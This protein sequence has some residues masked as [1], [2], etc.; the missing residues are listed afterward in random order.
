MMMPEMMMSPYV[1][2]LNVTDE[3]WN[4]LH[5]MTSQNFSGS[6]PEACD[7][8]DT[9]QH[10]RWHGRDQGLD[11]DRSAGGVERGKGQGGSKCNGSDQ[12]I[13]SGKGKRKSQSEEQDDLR[14]DSSH[15]SCL[16][17][18]SKNGKGTMAML[19]NSC[20]DRGQQQVRE[21]DRVFSVQPSHE[22]CPRDQLSSQLHEVRSWTQC[23]G[24]TG[25]V[26]CDGMEAGRAE[27]QHSEEHDQSGGVREGDST[28]QVRKVT[29]QQGEGEEPSFGR[30]TSCGLRRF[31]R[32]DG[33]G[34]EEGRDREEEQDWPDIEEGEWQ[35]SLIQFMTKDQ[36]ENLQQSVK[37]NFSEFDASRALREL[38]GKVCETEHVWEI[39]CSPE[40]R[41]SEEAKR[42]GFKTTRWNWESGFDLGSAVKVDNMI[43]KIPKEKP[44]RVWASPKCTAVSSIQ[45]LNQRTEEQRKELQKKRMR[46]RREIRHLMRIFKAAY[47]R[48]P[49]SVH[50]YMEWPKS[51]TY[52]WRMREWHELE[53]WLRQKFQQPL[54]STEMHGCM[55][56]LQDKH[57]QLINKPWIVL[58]TDFDF[59]QSA[60][61]VCDWSHKHRQ[62]IGL[63]TDAV[64]NAAYYPQRMVSRIVQVWKKQWH[65]VQEAD[66]VRKLFL[67]QSQQSDFLEAKEG[68]DRMCNLAF[69]IE[70]SRGLV[71]S[72]PRD[73]VLSKPRDLVSSKSQSQ[74]SE[75]MG[76]AGGKHGLEDE[77]TTEQ[78]EQARA[79]LHKL[80]R[81]AGHPA[82]K[83]LAKLCRDRKLSPW[84]VEEASN[85]Q[86]PACISTARGSQKIIPSSIGDHIQPWQF[87]AMDAFDLH[88]PAQRLKARYVLMGCCAMHFVAIACTW[89]GDM[90]QHG[91]DPGAKIIQTF[92]DSWLLH[93]PRPQWVIMD[94]QTSFSKGVFPEFLEMIGVGSLVTAAEAHWQN[95]VAESMIG[96]AKRT[97]RR[98]RNE[99]PE[100]EPQV[101]GH[102]AAVA[103]N[104]TDKCKGFSPIQWA[105]GTNPDAWENPFDPLFANSGK[106]FGSK[107]FSDFA[108][109][110][111]RA[112]QINTEERARTMTSRLL[113]SA[114]RPPDRYAVGDHV[115]IWRSATLKARKRDETYNPEPRFIGPGRIVLIEPAVSPD[116]RAGVIWVLFGSTIYRCAPEQLR[117]ASQQ[118]LTMEMLRGNK[119]TLTP[120]EDLLKRLRQ[121]VDI[122]QEQGPIVPSGGTVDRQDAVTDAD[123][124]QDWG[125]ELKRGSK[126]SMSDSE[127]SMSPEQRRRTEVASMKREW[128][129]LVSLNRNRRQEGLPRI[130]R[131]PEFEHW[132]AGQ[133]P[134]EISNPTPD[135][136]GVLGFNITEDHETMLEK[137]QETEEKEVYLTAFGKLDEDAKHAIFAQLQDQDDYSQETETLKAKIEQERRSQQEA[138]SCLHQHYDNDGCAWFVEFDID[139]P[140][141]F[142]A[143]SLLYVKKVL[144]SKGT[145]VRYD[146]LTS[147]QRSLFDEA[148][149]REVSEV[150]QSM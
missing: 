63:G 20:G 28:P 37:S 71:S 9:C 87:V 104:H 91:T 24:G 53:Q 145:E 8:H 112:E 114:P 69:P 144:E 143:N 43:A 82:N 3:Q 100:M 99:N 57:G 1:S 129:S 25:E 85:L 92:C 135:E 110:R 41:L 11:Q 122:T 16:G 60:Y 136:R 65:H 46:T 102:L 77:I 109:V 134:M 49:G 79:M 95:G 34:R 119:L 6:E 97:M 76:S 115:C 78:R 98:L 32:G 72:K 39:C 58:T 138:L 101:I 22:L 15:D 29:F 131:L 26:A 2:H 125:D 7:Q 103:Q 89:M 118:E 127:P 113:H 27:V 64:H 116:R 4:F 88:F 83:N 75:D 96:V 81:A 111:E 74:G 123:S 140:E 61:C 66:M 67:I 120:K 42:Q 17:L 51:A 86:C 132:E 56:G 54:Y 130:M 50:L 36:R 121:Y 14:R 73:L 148:K 80:H 124:V 18:R 40:S 107:S 38:K 147:E 47:A 126:R 31:L 137:S 21:M 62:V 59:Y 44:T 106:D 33:D 10:G 68:C 19:R 128:D 146:K 142:V 35:E 84:V 23:G 48:N 108:R 70:K 90:S 141:A 133:T 93:R 12:R 55:F 105:Y 94:P 5:S 30:R 150:I 45:N 117:V 13:S 139:E 52:G 149:A